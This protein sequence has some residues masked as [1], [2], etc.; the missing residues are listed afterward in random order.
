MDVGPT[1]PRCDPRIPGIM[2]QMQDAAA[3]RACNRILYGS[4]S[5]FA[6]EEPRPT[7]KHY[8]HDEEYRYMLPHESPWSHGGGLGPGSRSEDGLEASIMGWVIVGQ[9]AFSS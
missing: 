8:V 6:F 5:A 7:L 4:S 9:G 2:H 1:T 3:P